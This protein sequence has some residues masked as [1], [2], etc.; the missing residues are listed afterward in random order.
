M[1]NVEDVISILNTVENENLDENGRHII[2][3][4]RR[5]VYKLKTRKKLT[6]INGGK[7]E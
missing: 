5:S 6:V 3:K 4:I 2:D 7:H 1:I